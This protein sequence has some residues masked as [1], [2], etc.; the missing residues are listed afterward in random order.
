M[1]TEERLTRMESM[2]AEMLQQQD[3]R[4]QAL[5]ELLRGAWGYEDCWHPSVLEKE[6][7]AQRGRLRAVSEKLAMALVRLNL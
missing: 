1:T 4:L 5:E 7:L 3:E 2:M 6:M